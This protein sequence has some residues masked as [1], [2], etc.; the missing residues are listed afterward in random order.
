[1]TQLGSDISL[2]VKRWR[3]IEE[4]RRA[5]RDAF[6][7]DFKGLVLFGSNAR[8]EADADSDIDIIVLFKDR[9]TA[10]QARKKVSAISHEMLLKHDELIGALPLGEMQYM[11]GR[12]PFYRNVKREGIFIIAEEAFE[13]RQDIEELLDLARSSLRAARGLFE[14]EE[15]FARFAASRAYYVMFY[16]A[17]AALLSKGLTFS[18]HGNVIGAF[19]FHFAR[20]GTLPPELHG[21]LKDAFELRNA[22]DYSTEPFPQETAERVIQDAEE[23]L[24]MVEEYLNRVLGN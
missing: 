6:A 7:S 11:K 24:R 2:A 16:A 20:E 23:F 19:G 10:E 1:M 12:S 5:L 22:G 3:V 13:L 15:S 21:K 17:E 9:E 14:S 18:R 8:G 4:F